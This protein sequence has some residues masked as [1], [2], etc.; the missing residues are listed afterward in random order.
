MN[1]TATHC[2]I[3][4][5]HRHADTD[6][7]CCVNASLVP[8]PRPPPPLHPAVYF[9]EVQR[10]LGEE[11]VRDLRR[12]PRSPPVDILDVFRRPQDLPQAC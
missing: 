4:C 12:I 9:P 3:H 1:A 5:V 11:V 6:T 8:P 2:K 7:V 10:I